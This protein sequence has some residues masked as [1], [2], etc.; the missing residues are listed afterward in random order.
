M[1]AAEWRN[2]T[3]SVKRVA[4]AGVAL[5]AKAI[6]LQFP[7]NHALSVSY[8]PLGAITDTQMASEEASAVRDE[9]RDLDRAADEFIDLL[10]TNGLTFLD[11]D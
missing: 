1:V 2:I 4:V 6:E 5:S 7:N 11:P 3:A 8:V 10:K 9:L